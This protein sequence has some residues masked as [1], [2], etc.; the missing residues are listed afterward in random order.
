MCVSC[1]SQPWEPV[2]ITE[3]FPFKITCGDYC[4][5]SVHVHTVLYCRLIRYT[6]YT[7]AFLLICRCVLLSLHV[8]TTE[9]L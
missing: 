3:D 9:H 2:S 4:G 8:Q 7:I 6:Y 5:M 1:S